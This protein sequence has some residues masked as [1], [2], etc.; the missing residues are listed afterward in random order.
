MWISFIFSHVFRVALIAKFAIPAAAVAAL[1]TW[2]LASPDP[3]GMG[4]DRYGQLRLW[5]RGLG[6]VQFATTLVVL[7]STS[8]A[9]STYFL[10]R[11]LQ[12]L[13]LTAWGA[14]MLWYLD[15]LV[16]R[17]EQFK[18]GIS[19]RT[20][21]LLFLFLAASAISLAAWMMQMLGSGTKNPLAFFLGFPFSSLN[22]LLVYGAVGGFDKVLKAEV[23]AARGRTL[24][25]WRTAGASI[26]W[27]KQFLRRQNGN[28]H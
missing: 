10:L 19:F 5:A 7:L 23:A 17:T 12:M 22:I 11:G 21:L 6:I 1:G 3:S 27:I 16:K 15:R 14:I 26:Y 25:A 20:N 13:A 18:T 2:M 28:D 24:S 4:E 9:P 8:A